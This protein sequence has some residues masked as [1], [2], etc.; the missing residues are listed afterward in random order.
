VALVTVNAGGMQHVFMAL[1]VKLGSPKQAG[2]VHDPDSPSAKVLMEI[3]RLSPSKQLLETFSVI[4]KVQV[5]DP[6]E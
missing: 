5:H 3:L 1:K 2:L 6:S 4:Q